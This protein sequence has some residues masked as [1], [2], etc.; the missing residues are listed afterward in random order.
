MNGY[1]SVE[2]VAAL[3]PAEGGKKMHPTTICAWITKGINGVRLEARKPGKRY[4]IKPEAVEAFLNAVEAS[5]DGKVVQ[6]VA[7]T[8]RNPARKAAV[9]KKLQRH[10]IKGR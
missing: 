7:S 9:T 5:R 4:F 2:D 1:L 3:F 6:A 8:K 10:G